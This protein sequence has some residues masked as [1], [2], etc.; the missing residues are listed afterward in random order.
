MNHAIHCAGP[1]DCSCGSSSAYY[2]NITEAERRQT[3][4]YKMGYAEATRDWLTEV[5]RIQA[6]MPVAGNGRRLIMQ[7]ISKMEE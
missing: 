5:R 4:D 7:L 6:Q 1:A 3:Y 2:S